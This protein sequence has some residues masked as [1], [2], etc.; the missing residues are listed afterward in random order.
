MVMGGTRYK[1]SVSYH[2]INNDPQAKT[3]KDKL[4]DT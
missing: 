3:P 2:Y 1:L 4:E